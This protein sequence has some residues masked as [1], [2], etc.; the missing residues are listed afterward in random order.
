MNQ[1]VTFSS[2]PSSPSAT[3]PGQWIGIVVGE[4][5]KDVLMQTGFT[6]SSSDYARY[7]APIKWLG[8]NARMAQAA[9]LAG[10]AA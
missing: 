6:Y 1:Q 10:G 5:S 8:R 2:S 3:A 4:A 9:G 7:K